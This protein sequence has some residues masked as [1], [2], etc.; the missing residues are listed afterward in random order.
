[1]LQRIN[2]NLEPYVTSSFSKHGLT[3]TTGV[4]ASIFAGASR[5]PLAKIVNIWGR[6]EGF[7]LV[8]L[9]CSFGLLLMAVCE[10]LIL[11][12]FFQFG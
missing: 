11:S 10:S 6:V 8:N 5:L 12:V 1:M 3:A 2:S 4:M 7:I 9:L